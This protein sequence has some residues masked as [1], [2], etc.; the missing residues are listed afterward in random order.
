MAWISN[1][2]GYSKVPHRC[3]GP[4]DWRKH[5]PNT[6]HRSWLLLSNHPCPLWQRRSPSRWQIPLGWARRIS[7]RGRSYSASQLQRQVRRFI[8]IWVGCFWAKIRP[9]WTMSGN[10]EINDRRDIHLWWVLRKILVKQI[11]PRKATQL[12]VNCQL[13]AIQSPNWKGRQWRTRLSN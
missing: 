11:W 4:R 13:K 7:H 12:L 1:K 5:L 6:G 9:F 3:Q 2:W 8:K 10:E